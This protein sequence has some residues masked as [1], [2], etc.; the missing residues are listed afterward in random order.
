MG[1]R[2]LKAG[3]FEFSKEFRHCN[4]FLSCRRMTR[5]NFH[6]E[7]PQT[8]GTTTKSSRPDWTAQ[9]LIFVLPSHKSPQ[10]GN[11]VAMLQVTKMGKASG[12]D[13][14]NVLRL[15][16]RNNYCSV[17]SKTVGGQKKGN[18]NEVAQLLLMS[19]GLRHC[20]ILHSSCFS[21]SAVAMRKSF[22]FLYP[23]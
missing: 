17:A 21:I 12:M 13:W 19:K 23:L 11:L 22:L 4:K 5:S 7:D 1:H 6:S 15:Q 10:F 2:R 16:Q 3:L 9:R 20:R 8:L 18:E 14:Q